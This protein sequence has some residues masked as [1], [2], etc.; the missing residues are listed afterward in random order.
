VNDRITVVHHALGTDFGHGDASDI[1]AHIKR[2]STIS[3]AES[4]ELIRRR[5]AEFAAL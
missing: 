2:E 1:W 4:R 3:P 5:L